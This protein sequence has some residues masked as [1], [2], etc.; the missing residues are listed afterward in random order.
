MPTH[1]QSSLR[2]GLAARAGLRIAAIYAVLGALWILYS[3][4][5]LAELVE[6][7]A[8]WIQLQ[9]YKGWIF[10]AVTALLLAWL[11]TRLVRRLHHKNVQ[12]QRLNRTHRL[13]SG[14]NGTIVRVRNRDEL[15]NSVCE[16]AVRRGGFQ[17]ARILLHPAP[18]EALVLASQAM[19]E[20]S[21]PHS[22]PPPLVKLQPEPHLIPIILH[23][24]EKMDNAGSWRELAKGTGLRS[25]A[26][27]PIPDWASA[28]PVR[29]WLELGSMAADHFDAAEMELLR[30]IAADIGLGLETIEKSLNLEALAHY[31]P[32]TGLPNEALLRDRLRQALARTPY[33]G[34]V[35]GMLLTEVPELVRLTD[36]HGVHVGDRLRKELADYLTDSVRDGDTV[37]RTGRYSYAILLTDMARTEDMVE[38]TERL[39]RGPE[40]AIEGEALPIQLALRG[41]AALFPADGDSTDQLMGHAALAL[42]NNTRE[43]GS[44][45][46]YS[47]E[48]NQM[49]V[50]RLRLTH[51]LQH[52][53]ERGELALHF[54]LLVDA[55]GRQPMGAEALLRWHSAKHGN[56]GPDEFIPL[57]EESKIIHPLG[58][59][60][61]E[62]A[63][64]QLRAWKKAGVEPFYLSVNIAPPQ[65][66]GAGFAEHLREIME[67]TGVLPMASCLAIEVTET[68]FMNDLDRA[69]QVLHKIRALGVRVYLDDFGT[70]FSSLSYLSRLPVDA[71][72]IDRAF[73]RDLPGDERAGSLVRAIIALSHSLGLTVIAE[74]VETEEQA[75]WLEARGCDL[76][77]GFLYSRPAAAEKLELHSG[78]YRRAR[79]R[80]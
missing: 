3:D 68:A 62:Q 27:L 76:L 30:E 10:V 39:L 5:F 60:V 23:D 37:A 44:C 9:T 50:N 13:L 26:T 18:G 8:Q 1:S 12:V 71:L 70:G 69:E 38:L 64:T 74:G 33:D 20:G 52:A 47:P 40:V 79:A 75:D 16:L 66:L 78:E 63:C 31:D 51:G 55:R 22:D 14:I 28:A 24:L 58:D 7:P 73:V 34:R 41:G 2:P 61:L 17:L 36:L 49:A 53:I 25:L 42:H 11:V 46:F 35:V 56:V 29:G 43:P 19:P 77:Q 54:Q 32:L 6:D 48:L 4:R 57:A 15:L 72:K 80:H 59:W 65:L 45:T 67:R 21:P